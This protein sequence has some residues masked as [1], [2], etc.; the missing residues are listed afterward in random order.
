ML[1]NNAW[2][3]YENMID[4]GEYTWPRPFCH[5]A[6]RFSSRG[7]VGR[8]LPIHPLTNAPGKILVAP[9][10]PSVSTHGCA[11]ARARKPDGDSRYSY[12]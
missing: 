12:S 4:E 10:R 7:A 9:P 8:P 3:G 1:V 5:S 2:A 6:S 11:V